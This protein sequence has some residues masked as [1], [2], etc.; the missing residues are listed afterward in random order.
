[1]NLPWNRGNP[2]TTLGFATADWVCPGGDL[3]SC[4]GQRFLSAFLL[5]LDSRCGALPFPSGVPRHLFGA[6]SG[7][8]RLVEVRARYYL[9]LQLSR[10]QGD[11]KIDLEGNY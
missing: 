4:L 7:I 5:P 1:M 8:I 6:E 10:S 2:G 3:L 11:K 9:E